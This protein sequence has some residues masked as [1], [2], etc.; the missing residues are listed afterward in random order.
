MNISVEVMGKYP[1]DVVLVNVTYPNGSWANMSMFDGPDIEWYYNTTYDNLGLYYYRAWGKNIIGI[2]NYSEIG[3]FWIIDVAGPIISNLTDTPDPQK[4]GDYVNI[5]ADVIDDV[6][7]YNT[8]VNIYYP[9]A[10]MVNS[11]MTK[12]LGDQ[13]FYNTTFDVLGQYTYVVWAND[14][15]NRWSNS[16]PGSFMIIDCCAP[17]SS[18]LKDWPDPQENGGYVNITLSVTDNVAID[19]VAVY[20]AYPDT[21]WVNVSMLKGLGDEW[22]Y[23]TTYDILGLYTYIVWMNDTYDNWNSTGIGTFTIIDTDGPLFSNLDDTPDPQENGLTVNITVDVTDDVAVDTVSVNITYPDGSTIN[24]TMLKGLGDQWFY[25]DTYFNI[26]LHSYTVW[27]NDISNNW[28]NTGPGTFLIYDDDAPYFFSV[29]D[30]PD[31]QMLGGYV[32]ITACIID[33]VSVYGANVNITSP[34]GT[35]VNVSMMWDKGIEWIYNSTYFIPGVYNYTVWANDTSDIWNSAGPQNFTIL[36]TTPPEIS[37]L[38]AT[39]NPQEAGHNVKISALIIDDIAVAGASVRITYPLGTWINV[40]MTLSS[41]VEWIY[42]STYFALG[43]YSYTVWAN[44]ITNRWNSSGPKTFTIIDT[45]PPEITNLKATPNPQD[46]EGLVNVTVDV[47]DFF[48]VA[49]V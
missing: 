46:M 10:T 11:T 20:I 12:G 28:N 4:L 2:W 7:L 19:T 18:N 32:K 38:N 48:G 22:F 37:N 23:N 47:W 34:L 39:P 9:N 40:S 3:T 15:S 26:S 16:G 8:W 44:D 24:A 43:V 27:A 14:T 5:S 45:T 36:D 13:W 35:W 6:A 41:G 1:I 25:N 42:N 31:P 30:Y 33:D 21:S 17:E 29:T 49:G